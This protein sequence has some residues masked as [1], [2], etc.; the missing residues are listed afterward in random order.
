MRIINHGQKPFTAAGRWHCM[1]C[2]CD[3]V[4]DEGERGAT[5]RAPID[6]RDTPSF[7]MP[8]P[9][10]KAQASKYPVLPGAIGS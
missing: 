3:W 4:M 5:Y 1:K 6:Q 8:C 10:C 2:G 7:S 9:E